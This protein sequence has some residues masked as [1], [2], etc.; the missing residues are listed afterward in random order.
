LKEKKDQDS[1]AIKL[2]L[3]TGITQEEEKSEPIRH[4]GRE[5]SNEE[6]RSEIHRHGARGEGGKN[7]SKYKG[8]FQDTSWRRSE[9]EERTELRGRVVKT[10]GK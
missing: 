8:S 2:G 3:A 10:Y 6:G 9:P 7:F 5:V 1:V 4:S